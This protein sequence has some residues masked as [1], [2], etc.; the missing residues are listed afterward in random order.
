[1][2]IEK[3]S[4]ELSTGLDHG[5]ISRS[6]WVVPG[7]FAA[8]AYPGTP[9]NEVAKSDTKP[10]TALID[11]GIDVFVNLT[12]DYPSGTDKHLNRYDELAGSDITIER[13]PI[14]D[15]SIPTSGEMNTILDA[16]DA[17]LVRDKNVYVHCWG[18]IGRTG[19]VIGCWMIRHGLTTP[20]EVIK[21]IKELRLQDTAHHR[22]SPETEQQCEFV[23]NWE[24][25]PPTRLDKI[26]GCLLGGAIGDA[27]GAGIEFHS[28]N[29]IRDEF[30]P[31]GV[32]SFTPE[33]GHQAPIT[34]DTQM[35]LF[36]AEGLRQ[37]VSLG[38]DPIQSV[39]AAYQRWLHTQQVSSPDQTSS[40][41][42]GLA[43]NPRLYS[44]RA[45]GNTCLSALET[46]IPGSTEN[47]INNSKGCGG[48]MRAAPAGIYATSAQDAYTV[49]CSIAA[50][51]HTHPTGWTAA[52]VFAVLVHGLLNKLT[53][54]EALNQAVSIAETD[55]KAAEVVAKLAAAMEL[56]KLKK[57][58]PEEIE[59]LGAGWIAE[60]ALAIAVCC[61]MSDRS[62]RSQMLLSVN[63][64]GDSDSAGAIL[65]NLIGAHQGQQ[66]LPTAWKN[67]VELR[68]LIIKEAKLLHLTQETI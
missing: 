62:P 35:T 24:T 19:T 2:T 7:R 9:I 27:L 38:S 20:S 11:D 26:V 37:S 63:H 1:M 45:P 5:P 18:G 59:T 4:W 15:L 8:G 25:P 50:L 55:P 36:T 10:I 64:S 33:Y 29:Q 32:T 6:Y 66:A 67:T 21:T 58:R 12:Q 51:T 53:K 14:E 23:R 60:E 52:G 39:W 49:G 57:L 17:H 68:D 56:S 34:D 43:S 54:Q 30:G 16:I 47:L 42:M 31:D 65:G 46:G 40:D 3:T 22:I 41:S 48:V 28:I 13:F 44:R 61:F